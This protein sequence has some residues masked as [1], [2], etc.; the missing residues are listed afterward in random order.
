MAFRQS[1]LHEAF[2]APGTHGFRVFGY[3]AGDPLEAVLGPGYFRTAG[4]LLRPGDLIYVSTPAATDARRPDA[5][6]GVVRLCLLM[7]RTGTRGPV[8]VRL[9]QDFGRSDDPDPAELAPA[10]LPSAVTAAAPPVKRGRGRPPG[11][12]NKNWR[13][14]GKE[15]LN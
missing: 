14:I 5:E 13:E 7:V 9:V 2:F 4:R 6:S 15:L 10:A 1:D 8:A 3:A 12:R 11:S